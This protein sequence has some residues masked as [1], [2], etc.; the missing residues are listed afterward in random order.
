[1]RIIRFLSAGKILSGRLNSDGTASSE[2]TAS[3]FLNGSAS[4]AKTA[5]VF[6]NPVLAGQGIPGDLTCSE[7][8]LRIDKLLAPLV[9]TDILGIG[10]N[11]RDPGKA[12]PLEPPAFPFL[13]LKAASTLANPGES[14]A[15]PRLSQEVD[16]EGELAVIIGKEA[17][18]VSRDRAM[19]YVFGYTIGNDF[20]ARDWLNPNNYGGAQFARGKSFDGFTPLGPCIVTADEIP[21]PNA[22]WIKTYV[23]DILVQDQST[24]DMI[25]DIPTIIANLSTTMTLRPGTVILTGTPAGAGFARKPP[26]W[27]KAGDKIRIEIEG[28]GVLENQMLAAEQV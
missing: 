12:V 17:K 13:F 28:I 5:S 6:L 8:R 4:I 19:D 2:S 21:N 14:I 16:F 18:N 15:L 22:L 26:V 9:P 3:V 20:T 24:G 11:Y 25:S 23:N 27:L 10:L 7:E 1:M